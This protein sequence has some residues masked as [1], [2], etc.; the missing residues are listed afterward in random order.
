MYKKKNLFMTLLMTIFLLRLNKSFVT[1]SKL[2]FKILP[3]PGLITRIHK[4]K[5]CICSYK[6][7]CNQIKS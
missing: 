3:I 6:C 2:S 1:G 4:K 7:S 5:K